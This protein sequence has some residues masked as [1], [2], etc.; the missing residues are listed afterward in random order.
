MLAA[1]DRRVGL[2][3]GLLSDLSANELE[4]LAEA[5]RLLAGV[6]EHR[7]GKAPG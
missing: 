2:L 6:L 4:A 1:R 3:A 7:R 5:S